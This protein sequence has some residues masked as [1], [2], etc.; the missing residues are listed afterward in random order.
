MLNMVLNIYEIIM[1]KQWFGV[2]F[3]FF[4]NERNGR[5]HIWNV[6]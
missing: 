3:L 4:D 5:G 1:K 2:F 6:W